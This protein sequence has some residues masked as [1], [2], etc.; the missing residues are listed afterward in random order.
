[1]ATGKIEKKYTFAEVNA[2]L[3][4]NK[5]TKW[6]T[7]STYYSFDDVQ[8]IVNVLTSMSTGGFLIAQHGNALCADLYATSTNYSGIIMVVKASSNNAYYLAFSRD[9]AAIGNISISNVSV[10]KKTSLAS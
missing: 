10:S 5:L 3:A 2:L 8:S 4:E 6:S 7:P 9:T 1:M